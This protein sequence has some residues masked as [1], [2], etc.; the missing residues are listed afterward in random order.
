MFQLERVM[1][2]HGQMQCRTCQAA[3]SARLI[4]LCL[5]TGEGAQLGAVTSTNVETPR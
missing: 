5:A 4:F 3:L 1:Q 2:G